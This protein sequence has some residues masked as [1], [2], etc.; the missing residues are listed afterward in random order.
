MSSGAQRGLAVLADGA[1]S[2]FA[3]AAVAALAAAGVRWTRGLGAGLG[4]QVAVL[5]LLGEADEAARRWRRQAELSCPLLASELSAAQQRL[6]GTGGVVVL[7]DPWRM[8]GWL[9]PQSLLEHLSPEAADVPGRLRRAGVRCAVAVE[10]LAAGACGWLEL[11]DVLVEEA[12]HVLR[13]AASFP[14]GWG[15]VEWLQDGESRRWWGGVGTAATAGWSVGDDGMYWDI[16]CGFPVPAVARPAIGTGLL[17]SI[18]RREEARAAASVVAWCRSLARRGYCLVAPERE[19]YVRW[20][21]RDTADLGIEYP[22]PF[23]RNGEVALAVGE[24]GTFS[25]KSAFGE[26]PA[27]R[28]SAEG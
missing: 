9:D 25:A 22:L 26:R 3:A 2:A 12:G 24:F 17:E 5:A 19:R 28:N 7:P 23:E 4:A 10:D 27:S 1:Q 20:A 21:G 15:P 6:G 18:Q 11:D 16:V 13:A 8:G 14:A